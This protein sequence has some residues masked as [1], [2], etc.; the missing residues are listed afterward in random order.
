[1]KRSESI[2]PAAVNI[3]VVCG[4]CSTAPDV[5]VL[6]SGTRVASFAVRT[7]LRADRST[8]V[9]VTVW[10]PPAW[11]ETLEAGDEVIVVGHLR[12]RFY[13]RAGGVGARVDLEAEL[14]GRARDQRR[15]RAA[16][17]R[18]HAALEPLA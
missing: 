8:S 7:R 15:L 1:M 10:D 18:A 9:P 11:L 6:P 4:P 2:E 12:R 3:S 17:R 5:R 14:V 13:Q 16:V